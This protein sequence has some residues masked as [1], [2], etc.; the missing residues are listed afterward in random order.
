MSQ[1]DYHTKDNLS[2][3]DL[4]PFEQK[5]EQKQS[6]RHKTIAHSSA[7]LIDADVHTQVDDFVDKRNPSQTEQKYVQ[8]ELL[9]SANYQSWLDAD[10]LPQL[11]HTVF[12]NKSLDIKFSV[13][14][15]FW[16]WSKEIS[17]F[18]FTE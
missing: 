1:I 2:P 6:K 16:F 5:Y 4:N 14:F 11:Q 10:M 3:K 17:W 7:L 12:S 9:T 15:C 8:S 13:D 18:L